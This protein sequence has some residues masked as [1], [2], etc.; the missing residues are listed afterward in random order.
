TIIRQVGDIGRMV[1]EFSAF[2][3]MPKPAMERRDLREV[4]REAAFLVEVSRNEIAFERDYGDTP[5][6]GMFDGRLMSQA[7]GNLIKNAAEATE[8]V[9]YEPGT[10]ATIRI[11]ARAAGDRIIVEVLDNGRGLPAQ[12]RQRLLEPYVTTRE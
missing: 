3:R 10:R 12:N 9:T 5:L 6:V 1:D 7:F 11:T 2:A 8:T 4:L